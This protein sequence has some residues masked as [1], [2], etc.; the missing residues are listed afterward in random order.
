[1]IVLLV[2]FDQ[3]ILNYTNTSIFRP[4]RP[5]TRTIGLFL[6]RGRPAVCRPSSSRHRDFASNRVLKWKSYVAYRMAPVLMTMNDLESHSPVAG[7]FKR[8]L[9]NICAA[10]T[11]FQ[12]TALHDQLSPKW[13][14]LRSRDC[15]KF[16]A[17]K[18]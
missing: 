5:D 14:W 15:L 9:S 16:W 12:L 1:M 4:N 13:A 11:R 10:F 6:R 2:M 8:N 17:N 3:N 7:L 18:C